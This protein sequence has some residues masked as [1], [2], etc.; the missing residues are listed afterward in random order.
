MSRLRAYAEL[1]RAPAALTVP[2]DVVVGGAAAGWP[3]GARSAG[4]GAASVL[5]Y[6]AG[7]ALNDFADREVDAVERPERPVPAGRVTPAEA[8]AAAAALTAAGLPAG[9]CRARRTAP[10]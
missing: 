7:M 5:L 8:L 10:G 4:L 2:G 3:Y 1:V 9:R 6:W